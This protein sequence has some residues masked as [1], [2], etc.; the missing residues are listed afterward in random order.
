MLG[1]TQPK[2]RDD[3]IAA[4]PQ[5]VR[6][7]LTGILEMKDNDFDPTMRQATKHTAESHNLSPTEPARFRRQSKERQHPMQEIIT[8]ER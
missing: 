4:L 8:E 5:T 6:N 7:I 2:T 1:P 3:V